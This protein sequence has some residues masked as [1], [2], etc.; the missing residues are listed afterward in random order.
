MIST[1]TKLLL[2]FLLSVSLDGLLEAQDGSF[3]YVRG[4]T[5]SVAGFSIDASGALVPIPG[6]PFPT[7]SNNV[8][9]STPRS[10]AAD[11]HGRFLFA[12]MDGFILNVPPRIASFAIDPSTGALTPV[13]GSP[14]AIEGLTNNSLTASPTGKFVYVLRCGCSTFA[15]SDTITVYAVDTATGVLAPVP[16]SV[17]AAGKQSAPIVMDPGNKF[18]YVA[19]YGEGNFDRE[20]AGDGKI[21]GAIRTYTV[22][23]TTGVLTLIPGSLV[24][25]GDWSDYLTIDRTG[26][27]IYMAKG[28]GVGVWSINPT[29]GLLTEIPGSPFPADSRTTEARRVALD[30]TGKFAYLS[31]G[32]HIWAY[33][34]DPGTG[35]LT[36][37][38][39]SQ[40]SAPF[41]KLIADSTGQFLYRQ[42]FN[43]GEFFAYAINAGTG[44]LSLLPR[45]P[46]PGV[47]ASGVS[48]MIPKPRTLSP[49]TTSAVP[50]PAAN[51]AGW[52]NATV[53]VD[54]SAL[55]NSGWAG[56]KEI[57]Y[58]LTGAQ[59]GGGV[60][61]G[62]SASFSISAEG[63]TTVTY[64][65]TD[66]TG[67]Q[68]APK[69]LLV[70]IDTTPP[71]ATATAS[72]VPNVKEWNNT[73]VTISFSGTD[74]LSGID[75]CTGTITLLGDGAE[76]SAS[77]TCRDKAGNGSTPAVRSG[78]NIDKTPPTVRFAAPNPT[79]NASGWNNTNVS[80]PF[81]ASDGLSGV[82]SMSGSSPLSLTTE[83]TSVT[84]TVTVTDK[85]DNS[86]TFSSPP[87]KLDKT[88]PVI[89][90]LSAPAP[91]ANGWNNTDV[92]TNF[93]ALD[94]LSGLNS[95][96]GP[97]KTTK[98]GSGQAVTGTATDLAGNMSS[99]TIVLNIDKTA[100]EAYS[101]FNAV[102]GTVQVFG[103]DLVSGVASTPVALSCT[104]GNWDN[105]DSK[106]DRGGSKGNGRDRLCNYT[107]TDAAGN[108][109]VLVAKVRTDGRD[110]KGPD[111]GNGNRDHNSNSGSTDVVIVTMEYNNV[112][113]KS[114]QS[115]EASFQWDLSKDGKLQQLEQ[116]MQ[117]GKGKDHT[118]VTAT[119]DIKKNQTVIERKEG[120]PSKIV[121]PG[122]VLLR[123]LTRNGELSI[124]Y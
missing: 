38:S 29:T 80:V 37:I 78:I 58:S 123:I 117:I 45:S 54:L 115:N 120:K 85:A 27:F 41:N 124:E 116:T 68:E 62:A 21:P 87:V 66:K 110:G 39:S 59:A 113:I 107:I 77:G 109:L 103:R 9:N 53:T 102:T 104:P 13:P 22:N 3:L 64:F 47:G 42:G 69:T 108:K 75:S 72:P 25:M 12:A 90:A 34:I 63:I 40:P 20:S 61:S 92:T 32:A 30:P 82:A 74:T 4:P 70:S 118:E 26:R 93:T 106:D 11:P 79:A 35:A 31:D 67:N 105:D 55:D 114:I 17:V 18:A 7:T 5:G 57:K 96:S 81:T 89:S 16:G 56:V 97:I 14:F 98:D 33:A 8:P 44:E 23:P 24:V 28:A 122:L 51:T 112:A 19:S 111:A 91:N 48:L 46:F 86:A 84:G 94:T 6:S 121:K 71:S 1:S 76:Q 65:A 119:F 73:N 49:P 2:V 50:S 83:D 60:V 36:T 95:F 100:P 52:N 101:Q 10:L 99:V 15:G 43:N 88:P